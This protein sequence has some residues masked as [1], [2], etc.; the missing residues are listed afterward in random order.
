M[1]TI[2][3]GGLSDCDAEEASEQPLNLIDEEAKKESSLL[4]YINFSKELPEKE[5]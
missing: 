4:S 1:P 3:E 5:R 2:D